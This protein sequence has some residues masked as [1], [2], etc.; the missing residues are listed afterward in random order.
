[1]ALGRRVGRTQIALV[2]V[3]TLL[4]G[5]ALRPVAA[6][7]TP[8]TP[9][10]PTLASVTVKLNSLGRETERLAERFNKA[11]IDV[12][13]AEHEAAR[14]ER[15]ARNSAADYRAARVKFVQIITTQ[16]EYGSTNAV[17]ALMTSDSG[18]QYVAQL[19]GL[20]LLAQHQA[21]V[22]GE[23]RQAK[24]SMASVRKQANVVLRAAQVQR[25]VVNHQRAAAAAQTTKFQALFAT[26]TAAQQEAYANRMAAKAAADRRAAAASSDQTTQGGTPGTSHSGRPLITVH[27]G[28]AA[29][30]R[31]V[32]FAL[33]QLGKPYAFGAAGPHSYDCS[34]LTMAAW[35]AG[36]VSLPHLAAAQY[37][38]GT[39]VGLAHLQPGDLV[40]MYHPIGHVSIYI[41]NGKVVSAPQTGENVKIVP[42]AQQRRDIVGATRLV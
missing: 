8:A 32:D 17:A 34:G 38:Y 36:G 37:H 20:D 23:L 19:N 16:Y 6:G 18:R 31:A 25:A 10:G 41:G 21:V 2:T 33:A 11:R 40:F 1:V 3:V 12:A 29:A 26:L 42:L 24:S 30:Q 14:F 9:P 28:N 15:A 27:A 4:C 39:H 22:V 5:L 13:A 35:R 7:A